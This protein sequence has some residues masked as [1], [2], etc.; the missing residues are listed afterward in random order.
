M[1]ALRMILVLG[2]LALF[3]FGCAASKQA[4][5]AQRIENM[6]KDVAMIAQATDDADRK[7]VREETPQPPNLAEP[8]TL[9]DCIRYALNYNLEALAKASEKRVQDELINGVWFRMLPQL[10]LLAERRVK[11]THTPSSS[12][13]WITRQ[14]SLEP[15]FSEDLDQTMAS[16]ELSWDLLDLAQNVF[17]VQ[18]EGMRSQII[19]EQLRRIKQNVALEMTKAYMRAVVARDLIDDANQLLRMAKERQVE[20]D[21]MLAEQLVSRNDWLQNRIDI[22]EMMI[23]LTS[24]EEEFES[25]KNLLGQLMG[26]RVAD[27]DLAPFDFETPPVGVVYDVQQLET[28]ALQNRPE[29]FEKDID[30]QIAK[31]DLWVSITRMFPSL[32]P[33]YRY[34]YTSN[35]FY[36]KDHWYTY[37]LRLAWDIL[38]IPEFISESRT[39]QRK[40]DMEMKRRLQLSLA[41]LTQ[42]RLA[43]IEYKDAE[44]KIPLAKS[45][46]E[47]RGELMALIDRMIQDGKLKESLL[48]E[49]NN[50]F[51]S[52]RQR[53]L[54][55][56]SKLV[57]SQA[58]IRNTLG[59]DW[60]D[61]IPAAGAASAVQ[62]VPV[63]QSQ[64]QEYVA[65]P[66]VAP[67]QE[68]KTSEQAPT[69]A[70]E[71]AAQPADA[72]PAPAP[73]EGDLTIKISAVE[74][75]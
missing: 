56:Y 35:S 61:T 15:S 10:I 23:L 43:V 63:A 6:G 36:V 18:Q 72:N 32:T 13:S 29:L 3:L 8:L 21:K 54:E 37:G 19:E 68:T 14:Q 64:Q 75:Q 31:Q 9:D 53:Y 47:E 71:K 45:V 67:V 51:L 65:T 70:P 60:E 38:N 66:E 30:Q 4:Q 34:D 28:V 33:Y 7:V 50:R 26:V 24:F 49:E 41:I 16:A 22:K 11:S 55:S 69:P 46:A 20:M 57:L 17:R 25:A 39:A 58:R 12:T 1:H 40:Q 2:A 42:L 48:L 73:K 52:A 27:F 59:L 5:Q 74:A 62:S 44:E